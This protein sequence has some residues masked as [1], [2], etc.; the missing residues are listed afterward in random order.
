MQ[1]A[2]YEHTCLS[3]LAERQVPHSRPPVYC[4]LTPNR[5]GIAHLVHSIHVVPK[6]DAMRPSSGTRTHGVASQCKI[7]LFFLL[8]VELQNTRPVE[9]SYEM[10]L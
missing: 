4:A 2:Q 10:P 6:T 5:N 8:D 3:S 7:R 9:K 1:R